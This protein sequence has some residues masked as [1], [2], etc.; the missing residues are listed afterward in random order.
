MTTYTSTISQAHVLRQAVLNTSSSIELLR[1][2]VSNSVDADARRIDIKLENAGGDVWNITIQDNGNGMTDAHLHAFFNAGETVKDFASSAGAT[3]SIG[4]K[5]LGSKTTFV[6]KRIVIESRRHDDPTGALLIG[7]MD[8]PMTALKSGTMPEYVT[9]TSPTDYQPALVGHGTRIVLSGVYLSSFNGKKTSDADEIAARVMHYLRTM[10]A[11]GTVKN[12]HA[13]K[14]HVIES[15]LNV[16]AIPLLTLE[17]VATSGS[18]TLGPVA[19]TYPIP[20]VNT[21]PTGGSTNSYG[22]VE[23]SG[24][25][26][27]VA[28]FSRY[29]TISIG[30]QVKTVH[31]DCTA[32]IAGEAARADMLAGEL[33]QGWTQKS[34]MGLHLCKD[35]IPMKNDSSLSRELL[36]G[37]FYYEFKVF[38]NCQEFQLNA[39]RNVVTNSE[40]DDVSWIW[41]D[42]KTSV[43]PT[44]ESKAQVY[45]QMK[46]DEEL[47]SEAIKKTRASQALK[48]RYAAIPEIAVT[49]QG[50]DLKFV[51]SPQKE[52]D[53]S[54]LLAMM[55]QSGA[56]ANE[57]DPIAKFGQY[58]DDSTDILVEDSAG[59]PLLAEVELLLPN[60][61]RH[62]HPMSSYDLVVVWDLAGMS[63]GSSQNAPWGQN[64]ATLPVT[65]VNGTSPD[66]WYLQWGVTSKKVVVVREIL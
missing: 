11:T 66:E 50:A 53:V 58:I 8:D 60:L 21:S 20:D 41:D 1:E 62:K 37:E 14:T 15:V 64:G 51:K 33:K 28:D 26:C 40:S 19:G 48:G 6:A 29:R 63:N 16:G 12:R 3:L 38:L 49:K 45:R 31:Y 23:N 22:I 30:G 32:I 18:A 34:Q 13:S 9:E 2:A 17:V 44:I 52:A 4:E 55:V 61:F 42:F 7:S 10:C 59:N 39:D 27:D 43:W 36:G 57:L 5:G 54:H 25:F 56:W 46:K 24:R 47:A 65:L 35:F